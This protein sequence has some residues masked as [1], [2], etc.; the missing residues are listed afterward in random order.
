MHSLTSDHSMTASRRWAVLAGAT[1][2]AYGV[3]TPPAWADLSPGGGTQG[4]TTQTAQRDGHTIASR[5]TFSGSTRNPSDQSSPAATP[6]G[7]WSPPACWYEPVSAQQFS[8]EVEDG[9]KMV[10]DDP[11]QPNYAKES[12]S[13]YRDIYKNGKY[14]NYNLDKADKGNWWVSAQDPTRLNDQAAWECSDLPFWVKNGDIPPVKKAVSPEILA[15]LAY[16]RIQLPGTKAS[17]APGDT[18]KVNLSTW[19][20][21]D[22]AKF[23]KVSVTASLNV[24]GLNIQATTTAE[25][26]SL[27]LEP[28]TDDAETYPASGECAVS[29]DGSVGEPYATGKADQAP[30]CGIKYLRSSGSGTFPLKATVTWRITWSGTGGVGGDLP[31]GTFG[32]TQEVTVQEIQAVNR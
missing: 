31:D 26:V 12:V 21:L 28:G 14:K 23:K 6:V 2:L 5:V 1:A 29:S 3:I 22:K 18:T 11:Q 25:P 10:A 16:N 32:T 9:Y 20:W 15:E 24:T 17:L 8:K 7:N 27:K 4:K 19:A 13:E 30:P